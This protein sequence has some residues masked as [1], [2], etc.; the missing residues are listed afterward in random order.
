MTIIMRLKDFN[1]WSCCHFGCFYMSDNLTKIWKIFSIQKLMITVNPTW[2]HHKVTQWLRLICILML[3]YALKSVYFTGCGN[4]CT[5][6]CAVKIYARIWRSY[7]SVITISSW[8]TKCYTFIL[9]KTAVA[10]TALCFSSKFL[11]VENL[12]L[13]LCKGLL[14]M[15]FENQLEKWT[16]DCRNYSTISISCYLFVTWPY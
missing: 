6:K 4:V 3:Q 2:K 1:C 13:T 9:I 5:Y 7:H 16:L 15:F 12:P 8:N 14:S 10:A 11:Q